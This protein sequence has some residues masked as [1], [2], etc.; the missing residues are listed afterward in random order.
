MASILKQE[1]KR[2]TEELQQYAELLTETGVC[3][4]IAHHIKKKEKQTYINIVFW[5][6]KLYK[7]NTPTTH[8]HTHVTE[9]NLVEIFSCIIDL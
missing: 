5:S 6:E 3:L 8:T 7:T 2:V 1:K 9:T 4:L